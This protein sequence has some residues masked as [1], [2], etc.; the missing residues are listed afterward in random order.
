EHGIDQGGLAVVH[1][2]D[3][4]DIADRVNAIIHGCD[5]R[6]EAWMW[7]TSRYFLQ[8]TIPGLSTFHDWIRSRLRSRFRAANERSPEHCNYCSESHPFTSCFNAAMSA[9]E[10]S[11]IPTS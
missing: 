2:R 5:F 11:P 4:S 10:A 7:R 9:C 3:D 1:V 6:G 8:F